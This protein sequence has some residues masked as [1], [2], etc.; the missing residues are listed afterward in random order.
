MRIT[1]NERS[2]RTIE[3]IIR[4]C[5]NCNPK[6]D[7]PYKTRK[8]VVNAALQSFENLDCHRDHKGV[9]E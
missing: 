3:R 9:S 6:C 5:Q 7:E 8:E 4:D 2:R 1:V